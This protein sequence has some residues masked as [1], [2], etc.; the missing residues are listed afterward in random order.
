MTFYSEYDYNKKDNQIS[1]MFFGFCA[2]VGFIALG[3][4][5][6]RGI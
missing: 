1:M 4:L 6:G 3:F 5:L 2:I